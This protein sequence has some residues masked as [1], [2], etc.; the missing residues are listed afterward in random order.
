MNA[1][2]F[3][4]FDW[5]EYGKSSN[6]RRGDISMIATTI[7][8]NGEIVASPSRQRFVWPSSFEESASNFI[9]KR[10]RGRF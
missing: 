5:S 3:E 10:V 4:N 2:K 1:R 6:V 9:S 7:I 8:K